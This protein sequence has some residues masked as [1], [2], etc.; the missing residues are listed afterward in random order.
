MR[1]YG[2]G[3]QKDTDNAREYPVMKST[4]TASCWSGAGLVL[5][6]AELRVKWEEED[7]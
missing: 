5:A 3:K 4:Q 1:V 6:S 2:L 7:L